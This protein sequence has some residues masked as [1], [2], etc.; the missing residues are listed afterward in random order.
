MV[1]RYCLILGVGQLLFVA[2]VLQV[3]AARGT[4]IAAGGNADRIAVAIDSRLTEDNKIGQTILDDHDCKILP[5]NDRTIFFSTGVYGLKDI[6]GHTIFDAGE[7]AQQVYDNEPTGSFD[8]WAS[9]W[10][11]I[12]MEN[13]KS[14]SSLFMYPSNPLIVGYFAGS[15]SNGTLGIYG[16]SI[17]GTPTDPSAHP[18]N[19]DMNTDKLFDMASSPDILREFATGGTTDGAR[20]VLQLLG[21]EARGKGPTASL[22]LRY[23]TMVMLAGQSGNPH[24]GGETA[25]MTM[26]RRDPIW[27]WFHRPDYCPRK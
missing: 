17:I 16:Q 20:E 7:I 21:L 2:L 18:L 5:L 15:N 3:T 9:H 14:H 26:E 27:R 13:Y 4:Y 8:G 11:S 1:S 24:I 19:Y 10:A 25:V 22:A 12:M 6:Y 23:E